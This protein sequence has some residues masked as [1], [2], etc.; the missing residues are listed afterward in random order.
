MLKRLGRLVS[1]IVCFGLISGTL[2]VNAEMDKVSSW[3]KAKVVK[4]I[5]LGIVPKELQGDYTNSISRQE[6]VSLFVNALFTYQK[7]KINHNK[8]TIPSENITK[9]LFLNDVKVTDYSFKDTKSEDVKIAYMMGLVNGTSGTTFSPYSTITREEV[10]T[11]LVNYNNE[12]LD[13]TI[14][15]KAKERITDLNEA[16]PWAKDSVV[17]VWTHGIYFDGLNG[18]SRFYNKDDKNCNIKFNPKDDFTREQA[19]AVV[20]NI[21][22][23]YMPLFGNVMLRGKVHYVKSLLKL[24]WEVSNDS[25]TCLSFKNGKKLGKN[26]DLIYDQWHYYYPETAT[27]YQ[28][29][30][31]EQ[32]IAAYAGG[33]QRTSKHT[34]EMVKCAVTGVNAIFDMGFAEYEI[35]NKN[36]IFQFRFKGNGTYSEKYGYCG[37]S[38][39]LPIL[40]ERIDNK[41]VLFDDYSGEENK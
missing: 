37:G 31:S 7:N 9:K 24:N 41:E 12:V 27:A 14:L 39:K 38:E 35:H 36:Y 18:D 10:A 8:D 19:I 33:G 25:I 11:M 15:D 28:K 16:S 20:Y 29:A 1:L 26:T 22:N 34:K 40:Y 23:S 6:F 17:L 3:A 5:S 21:Y 2:P 13:P 4:A 32:I 30:T